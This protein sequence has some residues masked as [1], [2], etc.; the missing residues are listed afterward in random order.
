MFGLLDKNKQIA[1]L[2]SIAQASES[3]LFKMNQVFIDNEI[4]LQQ[5]E[6]EQDKNEQ[7]QKKIIQEKQKLLEK[8]KKQA[9]LDKQQS[10]TKAEELLKQLE[11]TT[12]DEQQS[13]PSHTPQKRKKF[14]GIF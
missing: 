14:L 13:L 2:N 11:E 1:L 6:S 8:L 4:K 9:E 12:K 5:M 3:K 10:T 7:Q